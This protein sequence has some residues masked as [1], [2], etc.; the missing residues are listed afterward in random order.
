MKRRTLLHATALVHT[1]YRGTVLVLTDLISGQITFLMDSI[2]S[3]QSHIQDG[4]VRAL[5]VSG[6]KRSASLPQVPTIAELGIPGMAYSHGFG[7]FGPAGLPPELA[8]RLNRELN[9]IPSAPDFI[10][11]L[12]KLGG[13]V[14]KATSPT[15]R[16]RQA[17]RPGPAG[18]GRVA[19]V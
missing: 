9:T 4:Q 3:A 10:E 12:E 2:V 6:A 15:A 16:A 13:D 19:L 17:R 11:R 1:S 7:L 18:P 14:G 5:A 8:A